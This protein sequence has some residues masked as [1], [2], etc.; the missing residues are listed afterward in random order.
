MELKRK[1]MPEHEML[2]IKD[3]FEKCL[4]NKFCLVVSLLSDAGN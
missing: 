2:Y 1:S 3:I 4:R